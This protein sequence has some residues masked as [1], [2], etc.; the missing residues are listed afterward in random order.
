MTP[1]GAFLR[2]AREG[3][4]ERLVYTR[5]VSV[6]NGA[7]ALLHVSFDSIEEPNGLGIFWLVWNMALDPILPLVG[8]KRSTEV[9]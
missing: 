6:S 9:D 4:T 5:M 8:I 1:F 2:W 3:P 7:D